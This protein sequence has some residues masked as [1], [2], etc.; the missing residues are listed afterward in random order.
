MWNNTRIK[1]SE[2]SLQCLWH[3]WVKTNRTAPGKSRDVS[4]VSAEFGIMKNEDKL[5]EK[6]YYRQK[7]KRS[8]KVETIGQ[9]RVPKT[10]NRKNV[11]DAENSFS[12]ILLFRI[13]N[14]NRNL[15]G[16]WKTGRWLPLLRVLWLTFPLRLLSCWDEIGAGLNARKIF[17]ERNSV[18]GRFFHLLPK[19][20]AYFAS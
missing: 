14:E 9:A 2:I 5:K 18:L 4:D 8:P 17:K 12:P 20:R 13:F 16:E 10:S 6:S 3:N 1:S 7:V 15:F 11:G 19:P